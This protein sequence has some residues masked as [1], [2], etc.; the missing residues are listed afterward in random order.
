MNRGTPLFS[1]FILQLSHDDFRKVVKRYDGNYRTRSFSCWDQFLC[2]AFAQ[3]AGMD[4]LNDTIACLCKRGKTLYHFGIRGRVS[5]SALAR[6][7]G[8][9]RN[10]LYTI[11]SR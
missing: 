6:A 7:K 9:E 4:S 10:N 1:Q 2:M 8:I 11:D 5:K 3:L